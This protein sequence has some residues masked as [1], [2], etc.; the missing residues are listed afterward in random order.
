MI[1][2]IHEAFCNCSLLDKMDLTGSIVSR[3]IADFITKSGCDD[4]NKYI[5]RMKNIFSR[6]LNTES[7][8]IPTTCAW[9]LIEAPE[10]FGFKHYSFFIVTEAGIS[11]DLSS[12]TLMKC[13][14]LSGT[15]YGSLVEHLTGCFIWSEE[16]SG[17]V[18]PICPG[19]SS[20]LAWGTACS[21]QTND[22]EIEA[23]G[24][25]NS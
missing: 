16:L 17:W 12:G 4:L 21:K 19:Q 24:G 18:T 2:D 10:E 15:F 22:M 11:W 1:R 3:A 13:K 6:E 5:S 23:R 20:I 8:P 25:G 14:T 7:L 9:R